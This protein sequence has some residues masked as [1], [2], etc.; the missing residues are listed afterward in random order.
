MDGEL[1]PSNRTVQILPS[2]PGRNCPSKGRNN[3]GRDGVR[4]KVGMFGEAFSVGRISKKQIFKE[5]CERALFKVFLFTG[6]RCEDG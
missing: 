2:A 6:V 5:Q 4:W 3:G 1:S